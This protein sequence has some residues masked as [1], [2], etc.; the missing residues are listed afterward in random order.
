MTN[1]TNQLEACPHAA[2]SALRPKLVL[3]GSFQLSASS[4]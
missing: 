1:P 4:F 3:K 2:T